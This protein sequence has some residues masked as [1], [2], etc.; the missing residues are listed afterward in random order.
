M[1]AGD[2]DRVNS[3]MLVSSN[4]G[5]IDE[6]TQRSWYAI[7]KE[8]KD[9]LKTPTNTERDEIL[10]DCG[11]CIHRGCCGWTANA[12]IDPEKCGEYLYDSG[13]TSPVS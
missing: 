11:N 6:D 4:S 8:I 1:K 10:P 5:K 9:I 3:F 12:V 7:R 13:K 2:L